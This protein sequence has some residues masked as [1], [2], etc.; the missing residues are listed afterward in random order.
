MILINLLPYRELAREEKQKQF[1]RTNILCV[2]LGAVLSGVTYFLLEQAITNQ[3]VRNTALKDAIA[4]AKEDEKKVEVLRKEREMLLAKKKKVEEL[5]QER[6]RAAKMVDEITAALPPGT[7]LTSI[8]TASANSGAASYTLVGKSTSDNRIASF[9]SN[10]PRTGMFTIPVLTGI[11]KG[12]NAQDFTLVVTLAPYGAK[13]PEFT[14][15][16]AAVAVQNAPVTSDDM[17]NANA[18][19]EGVPTTNSNPPSEVPAAP[20]ETEKVGG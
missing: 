7:Y 1:T 10:L 15:A 9:M 5:Q 13:P 14:A 17:G 4:L 20:A 3:E 8:K 11:R 2:V 19:A 18:S 6:G 12:S 16:D